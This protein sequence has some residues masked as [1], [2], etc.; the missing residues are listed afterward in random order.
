MT[1]LI[2]ISG[3]LRQASLNTTLLEAD[4]RNVLF[5]TLAEVFPYP[6]VLVGQARQRLV[7]GQLTD[8]GTR[9]IIGEMLERYVAWIKRSA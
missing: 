1:N 3:S 9:K 2:G 5:G 6:E 8:E 7:D 4:L